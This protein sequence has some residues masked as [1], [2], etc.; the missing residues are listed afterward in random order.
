[1]SIAADRLLLD[2]NV[3]V[4]SVIDF[5]VHHLP[6]Q[7]LFGLEHVQLFVAAHSYAET[8]NTLTRRGERGAYRRPAED[9]W[10][11][12]ETVASAATLVGLSSAQTFDAIRMFSMRGGIGARL[13]DHLI[14]SVAPLCAA[15]SIVSWNTGHLRSLFPDRRVETPAEALARLS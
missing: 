5:H 14:G 12:L 4:A 15:T 2:T 8:Y 6:S 1:M 7:A 13:Y 3:L 11:S 10:A 9:A